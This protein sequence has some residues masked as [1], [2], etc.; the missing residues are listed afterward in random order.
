[1]HVRT[2]IRDRF[3][4]VLSAGLPA[5]EYEVFRS[6]KYPRNHTP[7]VAILDMRFEQDQTRDREVQSDARIHVA[8]LMIRIQRSEAEEQID[9]ALDADEVN[10][11]GTVSSTDFSDLLEEPPELVQ[12]LFTD[13][14]SS[15][16]VIGVIVMRYDVE[17]RI[18]YTDPETVIA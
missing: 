8:S 9:D 7:G 17:Y 12:V 11:V 13:D 14:A 16:Q 4:D 5:G 2:Q 6:R 10:V 15:G 1:M 3:A 18:E